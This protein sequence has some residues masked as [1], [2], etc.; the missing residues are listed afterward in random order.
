[1]LWAKR[2]EHT[3]NSLSL[4]GVLRLDLREGL[5]FLGLDV[6]E[7]RGGQHLLL[8]RFLLDDDLGFRLALGGSLFL[9]HRSVIRA[10]AVVAAVANAG[11]RLDP[12]LGGSL[13]F[14]RGGGALLGVCFLGRGGSLV[15][16]FGALLAPIGL[17]AVLGDGLD[18]TLISFGTVSTLSLVSGL[19]VFPWCRKWD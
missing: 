14:L 19:Q 11:G 2:N 15:V 3:R 17:G 5:E 6:A 9:L 16:G 12:F 7:G 18:E 1:M 13:L 8:D 4:S 10:A